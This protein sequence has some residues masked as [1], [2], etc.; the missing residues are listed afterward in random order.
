[1]KSIARNTLAYTGIVT[2]SQYIGNKK[3]KIAQC[4][5]TGG[6]SLF[7]LLADFFV[8]E[9]DKAAAERPKKVKLVNR[10]AGDRLE[11]GY[12]YEEAAAGFV[13]LYGNPTITTSSSSECRVKYSFLIS[14]DLMENI[15]DYTGLGIGLYP[16]NATEQ[17]ID[18]FIAFCPLNEKVSRGQLANAT[19]VVDW[20]LVIANG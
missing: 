11:D 16:K 7:S 17:D 14:R 1:M 19:L 6:A 12:Y 3:V 15:T 8:G 20:E 2:L 4:H 5:N 9:I 13:Y 18:K 10:R